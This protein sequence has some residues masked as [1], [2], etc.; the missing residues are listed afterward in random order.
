MKIHP[1]YLMKTKALNIT[2]LPDVQGG[3]KLIFTL[4]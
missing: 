3:I 4:P 2:A 1:L